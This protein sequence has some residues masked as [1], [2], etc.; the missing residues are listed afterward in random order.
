MNKI[1][2]QFFKTSF[3]ELI[4]GEF[5]GKI[6]LCDWKYRRMRTAIDRRIQRGLE[7]S[8][9]EKSSPVIRKAQSQLEEYF[10]GRR[11]DFE[12]PLLL[13]GTPFQKHVW[14]ELLK[15][16]FGKTESYSGLSKKIDNEKAVRAVAAANGAN[17]ISIFIPCHRIIGING[18]PVG[19]AGGTS[20]KK[21]LLQ[22]EKG[23][24]GLEQLTLFA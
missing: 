4:L 21:K 13:V 18:E 14:Q 8:Y 19:Y 9:E 2:I 15:I 7:T 22:L 10:E 20:T 11:N 16:P 12:V 24:K 3:G 23:I 6:C 5:K 1:N 17:A